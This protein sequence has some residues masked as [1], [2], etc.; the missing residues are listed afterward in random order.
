MGGGGLCFGKCIT[1]GN[2]QGNSS[3]NLTLSVDIALSATFP[4]VSMRLHAS[5][6]ASG[7]FATQEY[8][9]R[10]KFTHN[11]Q[12]KAILGKQTVNSG[13]VETAGTGESIIPKYLELLKN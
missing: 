3:E 11:F 12:F 1:Q 4:L 2:T 7:G 8:L 13:L 6:T 9:Q 5:S 10:V